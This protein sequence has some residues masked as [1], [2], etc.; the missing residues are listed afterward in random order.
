MYRLR[1]MAGSVLC[2]IMPFNKATANTVTATASRPRCSLLLP[3]SLLRRRRMGRRAP[4]GV[5]PVPLRRRHTS[6]TTST[7]SSIISMPVLVCRREGKQIRSF[8]SLSRIPS[9]KTPCCIIQVPSPL[10]SSTRS[11]PL[12]FGAVDDAAAPTARIPR[13]TLQAPRRENTFATFLDAVKCMAKRPTSRL[14]FGH[15]PERN[16]S[17]A[18]GSSATRLSHVQ[19]NSSDT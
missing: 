10:L 16:P 4:G 15:M 6:P 19:T 8:F 5:P 9:R 11:H 1:L 14:T 2:L 12:V 17:R 3:R 13:G 18:N 7:A